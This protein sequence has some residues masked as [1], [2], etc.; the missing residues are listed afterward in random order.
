M[1]VGLLVNCGAGLL[2]TLIGSAIGKYVPEKTKNGLTTLFG[3]CAMAIG[4]NSIVKVNAM[5][6]VVMAVLAGYVIGSMLHLEENTT[7]FFTWL[8]R[9]L[10]LG[11]KDTDMPT[12][13][14]VVALFCCSGFGWFGVLTEAISG[15]P[16]LLFA[17]S[18]LD[19]FTAVVFAAM[20]GPCM[21]AITPVQL[22]I[23]GII[24]CAGKLLAPW[25]DAAMMA[26]LTAC[27]GVLTLIA[28]FRVGK[29]KSLPLV[30]LMPA[31]LLVLPLSR[32]WSMIF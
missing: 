26:D 15:D 31:L 3:F 7:D 30:D 4:I 24:F 19:F 25:V 14:T 1:P 21:C 9:V 22:V 8:V 18:V 32:L 27:G 20:L 6:V 11:G 13:I 28:G 16:G 17:K 2:G 10:H 5:A 29:I 12:F 23:M